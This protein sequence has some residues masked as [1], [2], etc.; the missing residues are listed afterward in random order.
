MQL[1]QNDILEEIKAEFAR[2]KSSFPRSGSLD[3]PTVIAGWI[4]Q[5]EA[6]VLPYVTSGANATEGS[7]HLTMHDRE[8]VARVRQVATT[9]VEQANSIDLTHFELTLLLVAIYLHDLGNVLGRDTH[10]RKIDTALKAAGIQWP[11]DNIEYAIAKQ[12]ARSHGGTVAGSKDTISTLP[13]KSHVSGMPVRPRLL[14]AILRLADEL[15]DDPARANHVQLAAGVLP[16]GSEVYHVVARGLHS[17]VPDAATREI[18][19]CFTFYESA[20]F[21][22]MLGKGHETVYLLNE[23]Y[24]RSMKT[25]NEARYCS[26]FMR[27]YVEFERVKVDIVI[28]D[29][30]HMLLQEIVYT[31]AEHGYSQHSQ[32]I[33]DLVPELAAY[34]GNGQLTPEYLETL[35]VA[36]QE[37]RA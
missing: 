23:I 32:N 20:L 30:Q 34:K 31:I 26:R 28:L 19:L 13:E 37:E 1:A 18:T 25:F 3:Y 11:T 29:D 22:R 6:H 9:L 8:H 17:Q 12:I 21:R 10:E 33:Y 2:K 27:P 16:N 14:A 36:A 5:L 15:A 4:G 24:D 35:I 7:G